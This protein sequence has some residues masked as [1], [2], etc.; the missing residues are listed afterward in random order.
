MFVSSPQWVDRVS[1]IGAVLAPDEEADGSV[2]MRLVVGEYSMWALVANPL[3]GVGYS[4]FGGWATDQIRQYRQSGRGDALA[5]TE[6]GLVK[7]GGAI[8]NS[9]LHVA[10]EMGLFGLITYLTFLALGWSDF[11]RGFRTAKKFPDDPI[12]SRA[13]FY[14]IFLQMS[15]FATLVDNM[16]LS[17]VRFKS[18]WMLIAISTVILRVIRTRMAELAATPS[19]FPEVPPLPGLDGPS[20]SA[21]PPA[22]PSSLSNRIPGR[23]V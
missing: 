16:F 23:T 14:A 2:R 8:H 15:Y 10:A 12:L 20:G 6:T 21:L 5:Q 13:Y 1:T 9:Y 4:N 11:S 7:S 18:A 17:S 19:S 3:F 22:L